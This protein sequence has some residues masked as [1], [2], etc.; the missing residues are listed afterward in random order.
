MY[1]VK[2][3]LKQYDLLSY[4]YATYGYGT[5]VAGYA[6]SYENKFNLTEYL[7]AQISDWVF[8]CVFYFLGR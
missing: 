2:Q 6:A 3:I 7:C 1:R 4:R 8:L 5:Y